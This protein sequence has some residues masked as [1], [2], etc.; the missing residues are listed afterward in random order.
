LPFLVTGK[1]RAIM[2]SLV[3]SLWAGLLLLAPGA[4][5]TAAQAPR[6]KDAPS[7][8]PPERR[9]LGRDEQ[10]RAAALEQQMAEAEALTRQALADRKR[11]LGDRHPETLAYLSNLAL[12]LDELGRHAEAEA[13]HRQVLDLRR[14]VM[15][16]EHPLNANSYHNLAHNLAEQGKFAE[17][18]DLQRRALA[19]WQRR[20]G[21]SHG[22]TNQANHN[23][24]VYL[25]AQ[26]RY[27]EAAEFLARAVQGFEAA[28]L[29]AG[30]TGLGRV[31]FSAQ[32]P[33]QPFFAAVL[34]R[35]GQG[36]AAW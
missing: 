25:H 30:F 7:S 13:L 27:A 32:T 34:A 36:D 3:C 19:V 2:R 20:L 31:G 10:Q 33:S 29:R 11:V 35:Q 12:Q 22:Q 28:R 24:A 15:G 8:S 9:T 16:P 21:P 17:A 4:A 6:D 5:L 23:L 1:G 26:G 14:E 18:E